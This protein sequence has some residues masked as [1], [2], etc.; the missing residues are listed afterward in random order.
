MKN[1]K[2]KNYRLHLTFP[3]FPWTVLETL[4]TQLYDFSVLIIYGLQNT[5]YILK[6]HKG[7]S[8]F[9]FMNMK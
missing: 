6:S 8:I 2:S 1:N 7:K 5:L 3:P 4:K 9:L